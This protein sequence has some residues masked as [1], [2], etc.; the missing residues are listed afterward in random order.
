MIV[1]L[2]IWI[3]IFITT[4]TV[5]RGALSFFDRKDDKSFPEKYRFED[6]SIFGIMIVTV[7]AEIWSLFSGVSLAAN[8]TLIACC[9]MICIC[10]GTKK[11]K[12]FF[13]PHMNMQASVF[14]TVVFIAALFMAY[15]AS[16]GYFHY[17]S[18]L[19]HGQSIHWIESYGVVPGLGNLHGRH[20]Y[21][22]SSF[23]LTALYS[24]SFLG[25]RSYH[26][27]AGYLAF[28]VLVSVFRSYRIFTDKKIRLSDLARL[29]AFYYICNIYDEMV[30]PASDY[31]TMLIF[32]YII[33]RVLDGAEKEGSCGAD[34]YAAAAL[35]SVFAATI[36]LS[37]GLT[38]IVV[39]IP[40]VMMLKE[41][42]FSK[43]GLCCA[44]VLAISLPFFI[45]NYIISGWL[46]YP[47]T[48][49]DI[50]SPDW[51]TPAE[52]AI[53]DKAYIVA[54][55]RGYSHMGASQMPFSEWFPHWYSLL[56]RTDK[57]LF[58][59]GIAGL[60]LW[61]L[62]VTAGIFTGYYKTEKEE[63]IVR[64]TAVFTVALS[65]G[66]WLMSSPLVRYGQGYLIML[67]VLTFGY[68]FLRIYEK[69]KKYK[70]HMF[71]VCAGML[72]LF[73]AYKGIMMGR[74]AWSVRGYE[75]YVQPEDYGEYEVYPV[76]LGKLTVYAPVSG[77]RTG[78]YMFPTCAGEPTGFKLR[79][80]EA[81][82]F[83]GGF[84]P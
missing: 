32:M 9:V 70:K 68:L 6:V 8:I 64:E 31:F 67:P 66:F 3:Y 24:F 62:T 44:S 74:Y 1:N 49:P 4:Y 50:F 55:G 22:S 60:V 28:M 29:S 61:G 46:L 7:F 20:G 84:R 19:Y 35:L 59:A 63:K 73:F 38:V 56:G 34:F 41:K 57:V 65:Y 17:D 30:S 80:P 51:K 47:S 10:F 76:H 11:K 23:A 78:Y 72:C 71:I 18:D 83:S 13:M 5:G 12:I 48:F 36:K 69:S 15:G 75:Y 21:N 81:E 39:L 52:A 14:Y 54:F 25:G 40:L 26:S 2:L 16:R 53:A 79:D 43:L 33:I 82:D 37:A 58:L 77:D 45:R 42:S 27:C